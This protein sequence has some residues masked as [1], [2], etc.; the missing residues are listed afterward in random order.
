MITSLFD[1]FPDSSPYEGVSQAALDIQ[2]A[3]QEARHHVQSSLTSER[4]G[5]GAEFR[6]L[7]RTWKEETKYQSSPTRIAMH[8]AYQRIIGMGP[9]ALPLILQDLQE[10]HAQ[11]FWALRAIT[12]VDPIPPEDRGFVYR[13]VNAWIAW[14]IRKQIV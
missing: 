3:Y 11:W 13:M 2:A 6:T 9:Q 7:T 10:T 1:A 12:G 4:A 14:G 5:L 8:P